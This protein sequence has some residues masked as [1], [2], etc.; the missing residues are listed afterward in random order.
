VK[1]YTDSLKIVFFIY[2]L[3]LYISTEGFVYQIS[4]ILEL[5]FLLVFKW[6]KV[7]QSRIVSHTLQIG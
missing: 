6:I 7:V 4:I 5:S 2:K 1:F 3:G